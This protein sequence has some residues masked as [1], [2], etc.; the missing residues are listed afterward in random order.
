[1]GK[2]EKER[3]H[4]DMNIDRNYKMIKKDRAKGKLLPSEETLCP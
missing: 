4:F 1:M 3:M 2:K